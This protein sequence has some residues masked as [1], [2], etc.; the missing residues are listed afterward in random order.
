MA[1]ESLYRRL[2]EA[3]IGD[4]LVILRIGPV[5]RSHS[6]EMA[7]LNRDYHPAHVTSPRE[8][9]GGS[10]VP[11]LHSL[12][13]AGLLDEAIA[14]ICLRSRVLEL[15][16][17]HLESAVEG[18]V[19]TLTATLAARHNESGTLRVRFEVVNQKRR[20]LA[21]GEAIIAPAG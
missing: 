10:R 1:G 2:D 18:D 20:E 4:T 15:S 11:T 9:E 7:Q 8:K 16:V 14:R 13:L 5:S 21:R 3:A 19:L 12:W 6:L 17:D